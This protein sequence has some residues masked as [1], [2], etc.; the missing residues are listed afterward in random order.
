MREEAGLLDVAR[1]FDGGVYGALDDYQSFSKRI[2]IAAHHRHA[3][4]CDGDELLGFGDGYVEIEEVKEVGGVAVGVA[5]AEPECRAVDEW[6]RQRLLAS[7]RISSSP[8]SCAGRADSH[9]LFA[10]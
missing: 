4:E 7:A 1:Y 9:A 8:T 6:K 5:T 10:P 2:L 3:A